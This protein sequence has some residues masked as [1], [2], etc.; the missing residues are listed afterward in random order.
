MEVEGVVTPERLVAGLLVAVAG[1][2]CGDG[3]AG[4]HA[5]AG[6]RLWY[7]LAAPA[8]ARGNGA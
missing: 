3:E 7:E 8:T 4:R 5:G 1:T 6:R 2:V